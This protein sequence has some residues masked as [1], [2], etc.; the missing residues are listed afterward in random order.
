VAIISVFYS[1]LLACVLHSYTLIV[2]GFFDES[3][4]R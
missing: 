1:T 3:K 2:V 4:S